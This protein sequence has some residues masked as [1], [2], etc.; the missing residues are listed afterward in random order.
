MYCVSQILLRVWFIFEQCVQSNYY[1]IEAKIAFLLLVRVIC[2]LPTYVSTLICIFGTTIIYYLYSWFYGCYIMDKY[3]HMYYKMYAKQYK[4]CIS[5]VRNHQKV[6]AGILIIL[7][8]LL[9]LKNDPD[10]WQISK[11]FLIFKNYNFAFFFRPWYLI[12]QWE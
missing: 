9:T 8:E 4:Y 3:I 2:K 7:L 1:L 12:N 6:G 10:I 11:N 5:K